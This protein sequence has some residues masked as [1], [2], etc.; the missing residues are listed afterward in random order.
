MDELEKKVKYCKQYAMAYFVFSV[1]AIIYY[2][3]K[4][5]FIYMNVIAAIL[6]LLCYVGSNN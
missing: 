2:L 5:S 3:T 1:I 4:G 6:F